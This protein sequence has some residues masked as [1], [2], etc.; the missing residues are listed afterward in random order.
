MARKVELTVRVTWLDAVKLINKLKSNGKLFRVDFNKRGGALENRSM[1][2][3]FGVKSELK[4]A[5]KPKYSASDK[6]LLTVHEPFI[7]YRSIPMEGIT[8]IKYDGVLY[9]FRG[10]NGTIRV[11]AP[12]VQGRTVPVTGWGE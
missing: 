11:P 2:C 9:D 5:S 3:R 1:V 7:G 10:L 4:G 6:D 12:R 8:I